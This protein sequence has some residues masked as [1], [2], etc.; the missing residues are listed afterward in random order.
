M[1]DYA[2]NTYSS[3]KKSFKEKAKRFIGIT[4]MFALLGGII[5][6][7]DQVGHYMQTHRNGYVA[8]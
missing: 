4:L 3:G 5:V 6:V 8:K 7:A 1:V 2:N